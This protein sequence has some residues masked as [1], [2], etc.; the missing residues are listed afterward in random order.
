MLSEV[1][2]PVESYLLSCSVENNFFTDPNSIIDCVELSDGSAGSA[3]DNGY[4]AWT[5]VDFC[6]KERISKN[7]VSS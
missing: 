6:D 5:Y 4:D 7:L 2:E 3:L 1:N